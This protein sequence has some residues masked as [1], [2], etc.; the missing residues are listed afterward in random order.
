MPSMRLAASAYNILLKFGRLPKRSQVGRSYGFDGLSVENGSFQ[1][2]GSCSPL[3]SNLSFA[4]KS[5]KPVLLRGHNGVGKS[6]LL[7]LAAGLE[8]WQGQS[9]KPKDVF[10]VAQDLELPPRHLLQKLLA[11][12]TSDPEIAPIIDKFVCKASVKPLFQKNGFSGGE[13]A[14][15]ALVWALASDSKM[16]LLDEPFASVALDDR[17]PLLSAFLDGASALGKWTIVVSHD[18]LDSTLENRFQVVKMES[19]LGESCG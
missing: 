11:K 5:S 10:F 9:S 8:E 3:F 4:W 12:K 2:E 16:I 17:E 15:L 7:R 6:T 13:R 19:L 14:R 1:Y 18:V